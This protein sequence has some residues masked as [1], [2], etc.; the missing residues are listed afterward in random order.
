[1]NARVDFEN[2]YTDINVLEILKEPYAG[3]FFRDIGT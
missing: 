2:H 1:M 3:I